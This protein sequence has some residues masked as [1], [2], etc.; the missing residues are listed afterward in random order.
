MVT[1]HTEQCGRSAYL[2]LPLYKI[3]V[4]SSVG[5]LT[6]TNVGRRKAWEF[7]SG[8]AEKLIAE[9]RPYRITG[10]KIL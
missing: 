9:E 3:T 8:L 5:T 1:I 2:F 6:L 7:L 4:E 10:I